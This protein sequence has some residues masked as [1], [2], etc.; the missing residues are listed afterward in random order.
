MVKLVRLIP[1]LVVILSVTSCIYS[2]FDKNNVIKEEHKYEKPVYDSAQSIIQPKYFLD[3]LNF[4]GQEN[5]NEFHN[6]RKRLSESISIWVSEALRALEEMRIFTDTYKYE[7]Y[8]FTWLRTFHNPISIRVEEVNNDVIL[9]LKQSNGMGGYDP[10][11]LILND[12]IAVTKGDWNLLKRKM[13]SLDFWNMSSIENTEI[14]AMDGSMWLLEGKRNEE[15][16]IVYRQDGIMKETGEVCL[17]L[18]ELSN[19]KIKKKNLH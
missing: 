6:R 2:A 4:Y 3:T 15:Y 14:V 13:D 5:N 18:L 8:R 16:H 12:T 1:V 19:L 10:G 9:F 7:S 11:D 17:F